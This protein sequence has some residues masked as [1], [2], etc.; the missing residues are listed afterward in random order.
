MKKRY[1]N[2]IILII[3]A[4]FLF[5][6]CQPKIFGQTKRKRVRDCGCEL[7][8]PHNQSLNLVTY[9]ETDQ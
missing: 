4:S 8:Q 6:S 2:Y 7:M 9:N 5:S 1:C 3:L